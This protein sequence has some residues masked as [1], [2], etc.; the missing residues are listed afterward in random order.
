MTDFL[1][2]FLK[3]LL[4]YVARPVLLLVGALFSSFYNVLFAWWIGNRKRK[5]SA[6]GFPPGFRVQRIGVS[7]AVA[8]S[9]LPGAEIAKYFRD[10]PETAK[11]R[12]ANLTTN[13][14]LPRLS[15]QRTEMARLELGGSREAHNTDPFLDNEIRKRDA[16]QNHV[17]TRR[18]RPGDREGQGAIALHSVGAILGIGCVVL[19]GRTSPLLFMDIIVPSG[20]MRKR[21]PSPSGGSRREYRNP[22]CGPSGQTPKTASSDR[23]CQR[24]R[25]LAP[26]TGDPGRTRSLALGEP[27]DNQRKDQARHRS[28]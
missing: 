2:D 21:V 15:F 14:T 4:L 26:F 7:R 23:F 9:G 16:L 8:V 24:R 27:G 28:A 11:A 25:G 1:R 6:D 20:A 10:H 18:G 3:F 22:R 12:S 5:P 13:V 19:Q 17:G